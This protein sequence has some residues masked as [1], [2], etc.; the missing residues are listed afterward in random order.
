[1]N[2]NAERRSLRRIS[3][4]YGS[5]LTAAIQAGSQILTAEVMDYNSLGVSLKIK[6]S[7]IDID[8][9]KIDK[10]QLHYGNEVVCE[11]A[12]PKV[13]HHHPDT[14]K[15]VVSLTTQDD[16]KRLRRQNEDRVELGFSFHGSVYGTDP[17]TLDQNLI[18]RMSNFS[19][20]GFALI[21]SKSNRH[22]TVGLKLNNYT[23]MIPGF[24]LM[25]VSFQIKNIQDTGAHLKIGC[26]FTERDKKLIKATQKI[27]F[28]NAKIALHDEFAGDLVRKKI[29]AIGKFGPWIRVRK[30]ST[31]AEYEQAL[32][33]RYEAYKAAAKTEADQTWQDMKDE[34]DQR[35][36]IYVA[37]VGQTVVGT[38][39]L[40]FRDTGPLP[41]EKYLDINSM[42]QID[43]A[44]AAEI[45]RFAIHPHFQGTDV[46]FS[47]FRKI[48]FEIGSKKITSPVCLAT[49]KLSKYYKGIGAFAISPPVPHPTLPDETLTLYFFD[50]ERTLKGQMSALGWFVVA[51]PS[52]RLLRKFG[53]IRKPDSDFLKYPIALF[54]YSVM[55]GQKL[56]K[57]LFV[58]RK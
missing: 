32:K 21:S 39:R 51:K 43:P 3:N 44:S 30:V 4:K 20:E 38:I 14:Q 54:E 42:K 50:P 13:I 19:A 29:R 33:I 36:I 34:Y 9:F 6:T 2:T 7:A 16:T 41:F 40:V 58:A 15:T 57:R 37:Y 24:E 52:L 31:P 12:N 26:L 5:E 8:T 47:L 27:L 25:K 35:S 48:I 53:F 23:L 10:L 1:M 46:F 45:T 56:F 49:E 22:L 17:F 55:S 11:I 18:F 28:T